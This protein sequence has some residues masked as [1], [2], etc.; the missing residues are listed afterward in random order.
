MGLRE[1]KEGSSAAPRARGAHKR[2]GV[3][4]GMV[5]TQSVRRRSSLESGCRSRPQHAGVVSESQG[6]PRCGCVSSS[7]AVYRLSNSGGLAGSVCKR[8]STGVT[9]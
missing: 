5:G 3:G 6:R 1:G 4:T 7:R 2:G 8:R 9:Q